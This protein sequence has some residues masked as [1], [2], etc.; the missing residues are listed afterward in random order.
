MKRKGEKSGKPTVKFLRSVNRGR[1]LRQLPPQHSVTVYTLIRLMTTSFQQ[2]LCEYH[3]PPPP[4]PSPPLPSPWPRYAEMEAIGSHCLAAGCMETSFGVQVWIG[5]TDM[6]CLR[7]GIKACFR[8]T[9]VHPGFNQCSW[10]C[11]RVNVWARFERE[12]EGEKESHANK[13]HMPCTQ[14]HIWQA[15]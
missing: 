7:A 5:V 15:G 8:Y 2:G 10:R 11:V 4:L 12:S 6:T 9:D 14:S 3:P 1:L 13:Y